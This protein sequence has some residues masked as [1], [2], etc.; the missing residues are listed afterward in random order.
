V[1]A[2]NGNLAYNLTATNKNYLMQHNIF[3][4]WSVENELWKPALSF[5]VSPEDGGIIST[6]NINRDFFWANLNFGLRAFG[7]NSDA[8]YSHLLVENQAYLTL[9]RTF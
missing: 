2:I 9:S 3:F 6:L 8:L 4:R 1:D 5:L 7:G